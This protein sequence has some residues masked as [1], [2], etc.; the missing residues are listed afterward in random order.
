MGFK[1]Y[2]GKS[3]ALNTFEQTVAA[4][5][6]IHATTQT[7]PPRYFLGAEAMGSFLY[8]K[9]SLV[10]K[11]IIYYDMHL[12]AGAGA[13]NTESG[14]YLA[15]YVGIGQQVYLNQIMSLRL[16]YRLM[17]YNENL[18]EKVIT[19]RLGQNIGSRMNYTNLLT[20]GVTFLFGGPK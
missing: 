14:T 4:T 6:T 10:G 11:S 15:P 19:T 13:R 9:L 2:V 3:S 16:D 7:N 12:L 20:L 5:A 18:T 17:G 8:G 1:D